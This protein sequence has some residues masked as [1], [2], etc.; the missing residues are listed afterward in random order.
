M[1]ILQKL[2]NNSKLGRFVNVGL[3]NTLLDF[4]L[5]N[6]LLLIGFALL[7]SNIISVTISMLFSFY[8]NYRYVFRV[9][10]NNLT[11]TFGSFIV[12]TAIGLYIIQ[13]LAILGLSS[14]V[15][16]SAYLSSLSMILTSNLIKV[17]ATVASATWNYL[18]YDKLVFKDGS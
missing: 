10:K 8:L 2:K 12:V 9:K 7:S 1:P 18:V 11:R 13:T 5:L 6:I 14:V 4:V 3:L 17:C 16:Q 15:A